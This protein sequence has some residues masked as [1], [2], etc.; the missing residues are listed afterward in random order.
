MHKMGLQALRR[1][2]ADSFDALAR[3]LTGDIVGVVRRRRAVFMAEASGEN[4][5]K[6]WD[7]QAKA[8]LEKAW[9][10]NQ[11]L[12]AAE[13]R[14]LAEGCGLTTRQV[15]IWVS[16][17]YIYRTLILNVSS[18]VVCQSASKK[19]ALLDH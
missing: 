4:D 16:S 3:N 10:R 9:E 17:T 7:P 13:K 15:S 14:K 8:L 1:I 12:N 6:A 5:G 19:K 18:A 2:Y 11:K